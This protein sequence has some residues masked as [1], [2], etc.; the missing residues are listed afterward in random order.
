MIVRTKPPRKR[1]ATTAAHAVETCAATRK[2]RPYRLEADLLRVIVDAARKSLLLQPNESFS[3]KTSASAALSKGTTIQSE[4]ETM[5]SN[6]LA[7]V[8]AEADRNHIQSR[9]D[10]G[11]HPEA[12]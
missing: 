4:S 2:F 6:R 11:D 12:A 7:S 3:A 1:R 9:T 5:S 10:L 8:Y